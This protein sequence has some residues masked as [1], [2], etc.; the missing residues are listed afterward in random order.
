MALGFSRITRRNTKGKVRRYKNL[1][2]FNQECPKRGSGGNLC[3]LDN[4]RCTKSGDEGLA[5]VRTTKFMSG[6]SG[7]TWLLHFASC[8]VMKQHLRGRVE[9]RTLTTSDGRGGLKR[10]TPSL[11]RR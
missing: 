9:V 7:G 1:A 3:W 10:Y 4:L 2:V 11:D 8:K 6:R 5:T